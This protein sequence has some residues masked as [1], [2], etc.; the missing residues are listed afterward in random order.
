VSSYVSQLEEEQMA[1]ERH[2]PAPATIINMAQ[3]TYAAAP[4]PAA[5]Y[6]PNQQYAFTAQG[7]AYGKV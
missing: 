3:P 4:Y 6:N 2:A 7:N 1:D 5:P